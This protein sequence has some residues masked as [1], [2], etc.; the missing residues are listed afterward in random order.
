MQHFFKIFEM[1]HFMLYFSQFKK[2]KNQD[3]KFPNEWKK[4]RRMS[5]EGK[6]HGSK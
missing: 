4:W 2:K 5:T 3:K 6:L 1:V